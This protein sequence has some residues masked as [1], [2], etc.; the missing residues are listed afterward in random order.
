MMGCP[1][2]QTRRLTLWEYTAMR[3]VWN[4]RHKTDDPNEPA[5]PPSADFVRARQAELV[6]LGIS[7]TKH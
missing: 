3:A 6:E 2:D 5:E 1:P 7:G 4:A